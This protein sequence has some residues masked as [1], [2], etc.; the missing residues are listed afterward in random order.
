MSKFEKWVDDVQPKHARLTDTIITI[1]E[2]LL[3]R[4]DIEY[5][6]VSGRTKNKE[7]IL[8][9]IERKSYKTKWGQILT[10]D[11]KFMRQFYKL[12]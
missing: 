12:F 8:E 5:L 7:S 6:T 4:N 3:K 9:K 2:N 1:I 11:I 10:S